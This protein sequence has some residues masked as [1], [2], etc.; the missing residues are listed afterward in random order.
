MQM[1][2]KLGEAL[3]QAVQTIEVIAIKTQVVRTRCANSVR[4]LFPIPHVPDAMV[5]PKLTLTAT[6]PRALPL[7]L[8]HAGCWCQLQGEGPGEWL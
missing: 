3:G 5:R 4:R 7:I 8:P 6:K 1:K 2:T